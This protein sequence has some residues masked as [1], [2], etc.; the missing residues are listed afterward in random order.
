MEDDD[1]QL[2]V[3][4]AQVSSCMHE[5]HQLLLSVML[6]TFTQVLCPRHADLT[7]SQQ[8]QEG[9]RSPLL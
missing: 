8:A 2:D 9:L 4:M 3:M 6:H 1:N 5:N 7:V